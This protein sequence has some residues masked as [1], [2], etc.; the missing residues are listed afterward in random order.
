MKR[1]DQMISISFLILS[2]LSGVTIWILKDYFPIEDTFG[3]LP[4]PNI[5]FFKIVHHFST[6]GVVFSLGFIFKDHLIKKYKLKGYKKYTGV[7]LLISLILSTLTGQSL[8][9]ISSE[10]LLHFLQEIHLIIGF[11]SLTIFLVHYKLRHRSK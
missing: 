3:Q 7:L 6:I 2:F 8:L 1:F 11:C 4:N 9:S 5:E 10:K